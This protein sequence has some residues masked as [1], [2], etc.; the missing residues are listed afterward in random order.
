M[1]QSSDMRQ[2]ARGGSQEARGSRFD[3]RGEK[4]ETWGRGCV[5]RGRNK[6]G[7]KG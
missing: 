4:Q 2:E 6:Q 1:E 3:A 7:E 5:A